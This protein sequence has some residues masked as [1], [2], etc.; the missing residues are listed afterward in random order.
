MALLV[1][2]DKCNFCVETLNY[3]KTQPELLQ[4]LRFHNISTNGIPSDRIK[5]VPTLVTNEGKLYVGS[6][7]R[8]WLES[9]VPMDISSFSNDAFSIT[10]LDESEEP[11]NLFQLDMYGVPLQPVLTPELNS[12][13]NKKVNDAISD[14]NA[15]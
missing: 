3:I 13:I 7:V 4:I 11:G 12:K 15:R 1:Y 6:E 8:S 10:N 14:F 9:M 2:S 5:R